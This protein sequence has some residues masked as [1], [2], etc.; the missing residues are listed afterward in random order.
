MRP[1]ERVR[2]GGQVLVL[3]RSLGR[4]GEGEAFELEGR[5]DLAVKVYHEDKRATRMTKITAMVDQRLADRSSLAA[6][7]IDLVLSA[8]GTFLGFT[9]RRVRG[10][11]PVHRLWGPADRWAT[12][13]GATFATLVR[14]AANVARAVASVHYAGGVI[15]DINQ[16]GV[17][18]S[19]QATVAL[20]DAD[21]FQIRH[22][23]DRFLCG[24]FTE[25]Y[26][27]PE[28]AGRAFGREERS[29]NHDAF[30]VAAIA[31]QLLFLG[32]RPYEGR[33]T[34]PDIDLDHAVAGHRFAYSRRRD[35]GLTP[36]RHM[37]TLSDLPPVLADAFED[38]FAPVAALGLRPRPLDWAELLAQFEGELIGCAHRAEHRFH[39]TAGDCTWCR[40]RSTTGAEM[41]PPAT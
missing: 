10:H 28:L 9:M 4:G 6:F 35:T 2:A 40:V 36:P 38:A 30:G 20:I 34:T 15:G 32:R 33:A 11:Q 18:V 14:V 17:L 29:R 5:P 7:P 21:S 22:G 41:F 13:P 37:P 31:F 19:D 26:T 27:P 39:P 3:G 25:E 16:S 1:G 12:F 24:V 8:G 23:A